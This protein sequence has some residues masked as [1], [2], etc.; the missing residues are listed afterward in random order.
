[1]RWRA[2]VLLGFALSVVLPLSVGVGGQASAHEPFNLLLQG[3]GSVRQNR[4]PFLSSESQMSF[5]QGWESP[6]TEGTHQGQFA[7]D[8]AKAANVTFAIYAAG[9]ATL[10]AGTSTTAL[11]TGWTSRAVTARLTGMLICLPAPSAAYI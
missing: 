6:P 4:M 7:T 1:M 5:T 11:A 10:R 3:D 8:W 2:L 9:K